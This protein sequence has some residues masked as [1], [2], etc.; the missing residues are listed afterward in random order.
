M[1]DA[2]CA[3]HCTGHLPVDADIVSRTDCTSTDTTYHIKRMSPSSWNSGGSAAQRGEGGID[4]STCEVA[5]PR[6]PML[7]ERSAV[8]F[9]P[10]RAIF[11]RYL[12]NAPLA[13]A[14][15]RSAECRHLASWNLMRPVLDLG[16][17]MG[18]FASHAVGARLDVGA[19][20]L[21]APL[22]RAR[23]LGRFR[24]VVQAD[25]ARLPVAAES[26]ASVLAVSVCEHLTDP[27][28]SLTE[29]YRV[30]APGGRFV[31]TIV[32]ADVHQH[33]FY[34][35]LLRQLGLG[36]LA[37][38][39]LRLHD[40]VFRHRV[41]ES[42]EWWEAA[43][44]EVGFSVVFSRKIIAP[45]LAG[46]IDFWLATAWPSRLWRPFG[47]L[48]VWRPRWFEQ[49]CWRMFQRLDMDEDEGA[50]L[51]VVAQKR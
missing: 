40:L 30:L 3:D 39:Y 35:R 34:P 9:R 50:V 45:R 49:W 23:T 5:E 22:S 38:R 46:R 1:P 36:W 26:F 10:L 33:L 41:L 43:L 4:M 44:A 25:A 47:T 19:D 16:C 12:R 42:R 24:S 6:D 37:G 20:C 31:A 48:R 51:F 8:W 21:A 13:H 11:G 2:D 14:L 7:R 18:E 28:A 29:A 32:L 15:F 17:G 27:I